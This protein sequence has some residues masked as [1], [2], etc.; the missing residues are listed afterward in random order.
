MFSELRGALEGVA[1]LGEE[2]GRRGQDEHG[3]LAGQDNE[4][5]EIYSDGAGRFVKRSFQ[6]SAL[7]YSEANT[8]EIEAPCLPSMAGNSPRFHTTYGHHK[9][10]RT[11][12]ESRRG[13]TNGRTTW[14]DREV[15]RFYGQNVCDAEHETGQVCMWSRRS[16]FNACRLCFER[17]APTTE[18]LRYH[19]VHD[20]G[21]TCQ[22]VY[23]PDRAQRLT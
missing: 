6:P 12:L 15:S 2:V 20:S 7:S 10:T 16:S 19:A 23:R 11:N 18:T 4:A 17:K 8:G 9:C 22:L 13:P 1:T 14:S 5:I 21:V 3:R